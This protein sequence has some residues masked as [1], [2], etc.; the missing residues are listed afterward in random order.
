MAGLADLVNRRYYLCIEERYAASVMQEWIRLYKPVP[1]NF[2]NA[3]EKKGVYGCFVLGIQDKDG[4]H[5]DFIEKIAR[6]TNAK[7]EVV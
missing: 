6:M 2:R 5:L 7:I 3:N 1:L 4:K